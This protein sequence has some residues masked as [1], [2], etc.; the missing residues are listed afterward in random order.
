MTR[1][2]LYLVIAVLAVLVAGFAAY[3]IYQQ[4]QQPALEIRVDENGIK[5]DGNG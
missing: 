3:T 4:S 1:N 2:S 5:V